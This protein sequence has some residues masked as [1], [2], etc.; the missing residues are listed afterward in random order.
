M[1]VALDS[2]QP[3]LAQLNLMM[4]SARDYNDVQFE[5]LRIVEIPVEVLQ[6]HRSFNIWHQIEDLFFLAVPSNCYLKT[7]NARVDY[8]NYVVHGGVEIEPCFSTYVSPI[9][10]YTAQ[11]LWPR[12]HSPI[13]R[14]L[15]TT[16]PAD[17]V[18][19]EK[20]IIVSWCD[21]SLNYYHLMFDV[22]SKLL[23]LEDSDLREDNM[24]VFIGAESQLVRDLIQLLFPSIY[25]RLAFVSTNTCLVESAYFI[26]TPQP[27]YLDQ[28]LIG[29]LNQKIRA[30]ARTDIANTSIYYDIVSKDRSSIVY[31]KRGNARNGRLIMNEDLFVMALQQT[32]N[33]QAVDCAELPV[34]QQWILMYDVDIV[35]SPHGAALTNILG[36][37]EGAL[38]IEML[39]ESFSPATFWFISYF[40]RLRHVRSY[41]T[42][43]S[44]NCMDVNEAINSIS[45]VLSC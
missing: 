5:F 26:L 45:E 20:A 14:S 30:L 9:I 16:K 32:F 10:R 41:Y 33:V 8:N 11:K 1:L 35:I 42:L 19:L 17:E 15:I 39:H 7:L 25:T 18:S 36:C 44:A 24:I 13:I 3:A 4:L 38:I 12:R 28:N 6:S 21:D 2:Q 22:G 29:R 31:L 34:V 43:D 27:S 23:V 37:K 40:L